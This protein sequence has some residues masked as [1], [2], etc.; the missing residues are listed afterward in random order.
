MIAILPDINQASDH[1]FVVFGL[2]D[3]VKA[4]RATEDIPYAI[5]RK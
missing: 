2:E 4:D 5:V 1:R 3:V